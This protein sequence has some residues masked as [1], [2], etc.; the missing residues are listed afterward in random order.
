MNSRGRVK[1]SDFGLSK[2]LEDDATGAK[3][4]VGTFSY[5]SP[6]RLRGEPYGS[7]GDTW[8]VFRLSAPAPDPALPLSHLTRRPRFVPPPSLSLSLGR[9]AWC[10]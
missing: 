5:M 4:V 9:S 6:E 8:C 3:T 2:I 1:L 10:C 7:T